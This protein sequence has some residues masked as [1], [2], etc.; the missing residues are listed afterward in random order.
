MEDKEIRTTCPCLGSYFLL[1][2]TPGVL[3]GNLLDP[4]ESRESRPLYSKNRGPL[5]WLM[6]GEILN[7]RL[8]LCSDHF[9]FAVEP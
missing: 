7:A 6:I 4:Q 1:L 8:S 3:D 2:R 5:S 9:L